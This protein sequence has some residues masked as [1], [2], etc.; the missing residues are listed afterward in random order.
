MKKIIYWLPRILAVLITLFFGIFI[1][2]GF[3]Y[4]FTWRDSLIHFLTTLILIIITAAAWKYPRIG[5]W[6]FIAFGIFSLFFFRPL[7][8]I[9]LLIGGILI[10][11]GILFLNER[12]KK[13]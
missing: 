13:Q 12:I 9:G 5:G 4:N 2:E 3:G 7:L 1:W 10:I 6:I 11:A 8:W